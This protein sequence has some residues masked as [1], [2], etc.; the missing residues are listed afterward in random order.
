MKLFACLLYGC[1]E[2]MT[3]FTHV[4]KVQH[5]RVGHQTLG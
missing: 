3:L 2:G 1:W 4:L 5:A